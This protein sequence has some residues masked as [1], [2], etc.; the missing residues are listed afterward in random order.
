M[1]GGLPVS[2][3]RS[4]G[5]VVFTLSRGYRTPLLRRGAVSVVV[6]GIAALLA[7]SGYLPLVAW[8]AAAVFGAAGLGQAVLYLW[9]GRF[10]TRLS[11][12][13]IEARGYIDRF[14]SWPEVTGIHVSGFPAPDD[15]PAPLVGTPMDSPVKQPL[16]R[17]TY[18]SEGG[19]R[20]RLATI[21][22]ARRHGRDVLLRAPLVTAWQD[23]PEFEDKARLV[24]QWWRNHS[25]R[26]AGN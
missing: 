13:G 21:R 8:T 12:Q 17:V 18:R 19:Y 3:H 10:Q 14:I 22:V 16:S 20:A 15:E 5:E 1:G 6:A 11:P 7:S 24:C 23:D 4:D 25:Q 9:R 26:S 2:D